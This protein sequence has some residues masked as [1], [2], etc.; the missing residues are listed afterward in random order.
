MKVLNTFPFDKFQSLSGRRPAADATYPQWA[1]RCSISLRPTQSLLGRPTLANT[2]V[3]IDPSSP[4]FKRFARLAANISKYPP[5]SS[6]S[7]LSLGP[8]HPSFCPRSGSFAPFSPFPSLARFRTFF[9]RF[10]F[11]FFRTF[12]RQYLCRRPGMRAPAPRDLG[13]SAARS[14]DYI[15][16]YPVCG[17]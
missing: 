17:P 4:T 1:E 6:C 10:H 3:I 11:S 7:H 8:E 13:L 16:D 15:F 9:V 2:A 14:H 12:S 5:F